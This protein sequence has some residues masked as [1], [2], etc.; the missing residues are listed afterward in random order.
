MAGLADGKICYGTNGSVTFAEAGFHFDV[1][2]FI[3]QPIK[4]LKR[5]QLKT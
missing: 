2:L 1:V 3:G 5:F 4:R